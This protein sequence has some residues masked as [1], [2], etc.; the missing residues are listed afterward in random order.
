[1]AYML[2]K[3]GAEI[4]LSFLTSSFLVIENKTVKIELLY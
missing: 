4:A 1:M 3:A 2:R